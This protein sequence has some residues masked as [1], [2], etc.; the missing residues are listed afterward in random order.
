MVR[1][2]PTSDPRSA[3]EAV[4]R[5]LQERGHVA[6]LAGG[7]V[8]DELL[9]EDPTDFDVA[10]DARP[11]VIRGMFSRTAEVGAAFGVMLV[12][13][14]GPT[15]EVAT[16][17]ADGVYSDKRRPDSVA[18]SDAERDAQ[19][20]D[21]TINA[22]FIDPLA[23]GDDRV[24][25]FVD[26]R[27]DLIARTLRAVGDPEKR[28]AEDHL[29]ALRAARF[30]ARY[31]L[32]IERGTSDAI[33]RHAAGLEGV[34]RE[35]IGGEVRRMLTHSTRTR[36]CELLHEL[37]LARAVFGG[38]AELDQR[39]IGGLD[40]DASFV[41]ALMALLIGRGHDPAANADDLVAGVRASLLLSNEEREALR[42]G[43]AVLGLLLTGW[44]GMGEAGRKRLAASGGFTDAF[45]VLRSIE[46]DAAAG[47]GDEI[48][49]LRS[50]FGGLRPRP[51]VG[52]EDLIGM[53]FAPGPSFSSV[54]RAVYDAQLEG[55]VRDAEAARL[56]AEELANKRD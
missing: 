19:R 35:R 51:L 24:I 34:S 36:A 56:L 5:R 49:R 55:R 33:R 28:L 27:R 32:T 23:S 6:Y 2:D 40:A 12:R 41:A 37:H 1:R 10:T 20:R 25:D 16:F 11:A 31:G 53:G 14:F 26:G 18:F 50:R 30:A 7:C 39:P 21:F 52:G 38:V 13:E 47:V 8:R 44:N 22:L 3:A 54:L 46:P 29:R 43:F 17:R 42:D 48:E 9:G 4:A 15:I 45:A